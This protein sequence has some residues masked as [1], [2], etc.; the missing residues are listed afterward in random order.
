MQTLLQRKTDLSI[1]VP[2]YNLERFLK[3]LLKSLKE[4]KTEYKVQ[5]IFVL[6][7]CTDNSKSVILD[8]CLPC[9]I[10]NCEE[11]GCGPARNKGLEKAAGEYVWFM[12]G[13]DWL[14][15]DTAIQDAMDLAKGKD[16]VR[17][18]FQSIGFRRNWFS[19][20]WQYVMRKDLIGDTR[21][22]SIQPC[23]DD[24]FMEVILKKAGLDRYRHMELPSLDHAL[25]EYN[26][27]RE[28]SNMFRYLIEREKI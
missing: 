6:N 22:P 21:F 28:G 26:Y 8:S 3:P 1:I 14:T 13:D 5:N 15:C 19:M 18:P 16:I 23:E 11:Q 2:V 4:Q 27:L 24:A 9:V 7:N 12:D 17:I 25:Y 10:L 20:V